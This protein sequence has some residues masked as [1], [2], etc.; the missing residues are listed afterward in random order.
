LDEIWCDALVLAGLLRGRLYYGSTGFMRDRTRQFRSQ[1]DGTHSRYCFPQMGGTQSPFVR[2][3]VSNLAGR[4]FSHDDRQVERVSYLG[5][6]RP[7][8]WHLIYLLGMIHYSNPL[9][10]LESRL[11]LGRPGQNLH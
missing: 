9:Y 7:C 6:Y 3:Y 10:A 8:P 4:R 2:G 1:A 11:L 5:E